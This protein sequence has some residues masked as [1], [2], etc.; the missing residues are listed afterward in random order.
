MIHMVQALLQEAPMD[1][2]PVLLVLPPAGPIGLPEALHAAE[3][4]GSIAQQAVEPIG[5]IASSTC[6][7]Q[8]V[9]IPEVEQES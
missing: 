6:H 7:G 1:L 4:S 5:S 3:P 9:P 2:Q 8:P